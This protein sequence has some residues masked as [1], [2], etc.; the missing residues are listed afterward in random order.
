[1]FQNISGAYRFLANIDYLCGFTY[2][3]RLDFSSGKAV[4]P[5]AIKPRRVKSKYKS[6]KYHGII[7]IQED[8]IEIFQK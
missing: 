6:Y 5:P 1:M 2:L 3:E 4:D 7:H 8:L